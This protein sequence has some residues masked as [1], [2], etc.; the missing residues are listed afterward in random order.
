VPVLDQVANTAVGTL[1]AELEPI[2][3]LLIREVSIA[4]SAS[5][6]LSRSL[7]EIS[8]VLRQHLQPDVKC[9]KMALTR[10]RS[11]AEQS[12]AGPLTALADP[13]QADLFEGSDVRNSIPE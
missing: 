4:A 8:R 10:E 6:K 5:G 7:W 9:G 1:V 11:G 2:T 3:S 13:F 12:E